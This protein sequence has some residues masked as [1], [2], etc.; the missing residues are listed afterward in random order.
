[1]ASNQPHRL[2]DPRNPA[3]PQSIPLQDLS[4]PPDSR[5]IA[6]RNPS[7]IVT[8]SGDASASR[9]LVR[10][11][12]ASIRGLGSAGRSYERVAED[13]PSSATRDTN[14]SGSFSRNR[15]S[16]NQPTVVEDDELSLEDPSMLQEAIGFAGL[17]FN[18]EQPPPQRPPYQT[19]ASQYSLN[20]FS[21]GSSMYSY[22]HNDSYG[23]SYNSP[24]VEEDTAP[25]TNPT[26]L[27]PVDQARVGRAQGMSSLQS[28]SSNDLGRAS[29]STA[30][31]GD[32]LP[33]ME[34]GL[35][36]SGSSQT[37]GDSYS[38]SRSR[39]LSPSAA[40]L[41]PLSRASSMVRQMSQ[42]II[43]LSNEP[44]ILEHSIRRKTS[45]KHARL[46]APPLFPA[47]TEYAHDEPRPSQTPSVEKAQPLVTGGY[48]QR[49]HRK[50]SLNPLRGKTL[51]VFSPESKLRLWLCDILVHP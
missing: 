16:T 46:T 45:L 1:M 26:Y 4:R 18:A 48:L 15:A 7:R 37:M 20:S 19:A 51:G 34:A 24:S 6:G 32:D 3:T 39:S 22:Q 17:S 40:G 12:S 44:E 10:G 42:R 13:S 27:Q 49:R 21:G 5:D 31:L 29:S 35:R 9:P 23:G 11:R 38:R 36:A 47:M 2:Y 33:R 28:G 30:M 41:G 8:G 43:N 25:L 14:Q 50:Q